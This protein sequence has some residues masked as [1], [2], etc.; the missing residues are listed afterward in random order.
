[1][2]LQAETDRFLVDCR[3]TTHIVNRDAN[4]VEID[5]SFRPDQ[6]YIDGSKSNNLAKK[7]G[8]VPISFQSSDGKIVIIKL[9]N[10]LYVPS[11]PQCIFSVQRSKGEF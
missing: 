5:N 10:V 4:F 9:E 1:M 7:K 8:T 6:H 11:F 2:F 3:A